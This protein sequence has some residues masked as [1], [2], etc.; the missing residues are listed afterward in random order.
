MSFVLGGYRASPRALGS[1]RIASS[2]SS[3]KMLS[4]ITSCPVLDQGGS[5]ACVGESFATSCW[6]V[7]GCAGKR[8][9]GLPIYTLARARER[10]RVT[11]QLIDIGCV[12]S[13]AIDGMTTF[14]LVADDAW[15][16]TQAA[17]NDELPWDVLQLA[18]AA[19]APTITDIGSGAGMADTIRAAIDSDKP[20]PFA[21]MVDQLFEN[22]TGSTIWT[23]YAGAPKGGH[24]MVFAGYDQDSFFALSSWGLGWG[25]KGIARLSNDFVDSGFVLEAFRVDAAPVLR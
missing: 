1:I 20:V 2:G 3:S 16:L 15:P 14:G 23:G 5:D 4:A 24:M 22:I 25:N 19:K 8:P 13:D 7:N 17:V 12:P 9:G 6:L 18:D 10:A 11:D 21:M